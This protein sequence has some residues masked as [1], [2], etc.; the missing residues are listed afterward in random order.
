MG[1]KRLLAAAL[2]MLLISTAAG[3]ISPSGPKP[4][5]G[6]APAGEKDKETKSEERRIIPYKADETTFQMTGGWLSGD[7]V[8]LAEYSGGDTVI[9]SYGIY[10]GEKKELAKVNMAVTHF[11][12]SA[13]GKYLL[14]QGSTSSRHIDLL[15]MEV[16]GEVRFEH[17]FT[18]HDLSF[19]WNR[20]NPDRLFVTAFKEDWSFHPSVFYPLSG[21][22][23]TGPIDSP[24]AEWN[25]EHTLLYTA[26]VQQPDGSLLYEYDIRTKKTKLADEQVIALF[27]G[28]SALVTLKSKDGSDYYSASLNGKE[29]VYPAAL[30]DQEGVPE[31]PYAEAAGQTFLTYEYRDTRNLVSYS[32]TDGQKRTVLED[33]QNAP[34]QFSPDGSLVLYGYQQETIIDLQSGSLKSLIVF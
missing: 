13:D 23:M 25:G 24:F 6:S 28:E 1:S 11:E 12:T 7:T 21:G 22:E 16:S 30:A 29:S 26:E 2:F 14:L 15:M 5:D 10:T 17:E 33:V 4:L 8:A 18:S 31:I 9:S 27:P 20:Q 19:A 34:L 3:C 32:L